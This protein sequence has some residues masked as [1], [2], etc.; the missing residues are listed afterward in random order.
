[1]PLRQQTLFGETLIR[2]PSPSSSTSLSRPDP[3]VRKYRV[4]FDASSGGITSE[5]I[6]LQ[7]C[8]RDGRSLSERARIAANHQSPYDIARVRKVVTVEETERSID[9]SDEWRVA[10]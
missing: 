5:N 10:E 1:M 4:I 8:K 9:G 3:P 7:D 6:F 2:N